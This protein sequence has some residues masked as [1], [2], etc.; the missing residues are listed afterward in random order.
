MIKGLLQNTSFAAVFFALCDSF[1]LHLRGERIVL[2]LS[3]KGVILLKEGNVESISVTSLTEGYNY[4]F[5]G[6]AAGNVVDYLANLKLAADFE[7]NPNEYTGVTWVISL[8]YEDGDITT[9]YHFG[10]M[11]IRSDSGLWYKMNFD[12]ANQL[13]VLLDDL[14]K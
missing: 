8:E 5:D 11:F 7:E 14:S 9:I 4:S 13:S 3:G 2:G 1:W 12:E 10:N 6:D